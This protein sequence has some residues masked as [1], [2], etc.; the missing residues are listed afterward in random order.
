MIGVRGGAVRSARRARLVADDILD[1]LPVTD[2]VYYHLDYW[3][4]LVADL[5]A[6]VERAHAPGARVL[7]VGSDSL[8][9]LVLLRLGYDVHLWHF[10]EGHL[11]DEIK[12]RVRELVRLEELE[13]GEVP[14]TEEPFDVI[15][16]PF[17]FD[18]ITSSPVRLLSALRRLLT[19][20]GSLIVA[21]G[22]ERSVD[23]RMLMAAGRSTAHKYAERYVSL[24]FPPL[25]RRRAYQREDLASHCEAAGLRVIESACV[26]AH[27]ACSPIEPAAPVRYLAFQVQHRIAQVVPSTRHVVVLHLTH[28]IGDEDA[29]ERDWDKIGGEQPVVSVIVS[30]TH[31]DGHLA[32]ALQPLTNQEYPANKYEVIVLHDG[33]SPSVTAAV[34][35]AATESEVPVRGV[36]T[37][38]P[39]GPLARDSAIREA[40]GDICAHTDDLSLAPLGWLRTIVSAF[41][42]KTGVVTGP[43]SYADGSHPEF[44]QLPGSRPRWDHQGL[45]P[46]ANLAHRTRPLLAAGGFRGS[47][48][49]DGRPL[50][51]DTEIAWRLERLGWAKR[52][53]REAFINRLYPAP[54]RL[55]W[56]AEEWHRAEE[57][58]ALI[59]RAPRLRS[60]LLVYRYFAGRRTMVFDLMLAGMGA[61]L[62]SRRWRWL[63]LTLPWIGYCR[64][65]VDLW[66]PAGW[67]STGRRLLAMTARH[68][69]W[70][71][72]LAIGSIRARRLVL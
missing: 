38:E 51:W 55:G 35:R 61:A 20:D 50:G 39:E 13:R 1:V 9:A 53:V 33:R 17:I 56:V 24:S 60:Q 49:R 8:L 11:V 52:H 62:A 31:A 5:A 36:I 30:A 63:V 43:V 34:D 68:T 71:A 29:R 65:R 19:C 69:V 47:S 42:S 64:T 44:L 22:N 7:L 45:F 40:A 66:P 15:V 6:R 18:S 72:G 16:A 28:R 58:P 4:P 37:A 32:R 27:P 12:P 3:K 26:I 2:R 10:E 59:A 46:S 41:D 70:A 57:L 14:A 23:L 21:A 25:P 67:P 54:K 48:A